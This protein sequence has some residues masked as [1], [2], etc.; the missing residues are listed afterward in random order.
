[1]Y[2]NAVV[3]HRYED[4]RRE[5]RA[6]AELLA[7]ARPSDLPPL[8]GV[9]FT[10]KECVGVE[11]MPHTA[12]SLLR[13]DAVCARSATAVQRLVGAGAI[14]LAV[15]NVLEMAMWTE[16]ANLIYGRTHNPW[17][18]TR[19]PDGS[20]GGEAAIVGAGA[21]PFGIA[22]DT[23][24]S[25]RIPA[26]FC[27]V[28][29]HKPTGGLVPFT[30]HVPRASG[31]AARFACMGILARRAAD[32]APLLRLMSGP[33]GEDPGCGATFT[34]DL[35]A[36][37]RLEELTVKLT[38]HVV[39]GMRRFPAAPALITA[40]ARAAAALEARGARVVV[41]RFPELEDAFDVWADTLQRTNDETFE[42]W[43]GGTD[44]V[45]LLE[46]LLRHGLGRARHTLPAL[47]FLALERLSSLVDLVK[48][49]YEKA[50]RFKAQL[51]RTLGDQGV[52]LFPAFTS[53][54]PRHGQSLFMPGAF[55][56]SGIWN[57]LEMCSTAVP[58]GADSDGLPTGVQVI[59]RSGNDATTI[60]VAMAL[61]EDLG[62]WRP[63][64]LPA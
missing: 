17:D 53:T 18:I 22:S 15:T 61:E 45:K 9:P 29:G 46:Q 31:R 56:L 42:H 63:P 33:D 51:E 41:T 57:V 4:A 43:L 59:G 34:V 30:G 14:P 23:G 48:G 52:L 5:A 1:M 55:V 40:Q 7:H 11:G 39:E 38:V 21:S 20:S 24:G 36:P 44:P 54:A 28:F 50:Q 49:G 12:G 8:L 2:L 3:A 35:A 19:T 13:K 37:V 10:V 47:A 16:T 25:I 27:G 64:P 32:L 26:S 62:G 60:A 6:C 58:A